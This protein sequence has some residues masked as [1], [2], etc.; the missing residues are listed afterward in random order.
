[1]DFSALRE[2]ILLSNK[3]A[4]EKAEEPLLESKVND[5]SRDEWRE[6]IVGIPEDVKKEISFLDWQLEVSRYPA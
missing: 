4:S 2:Q 1:M 3:T 5:L 6:L